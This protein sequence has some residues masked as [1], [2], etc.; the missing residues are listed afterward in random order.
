MVDIKC[1]ELGKMAKCCSGQFDS[2]LQM[3]VSGQKKRSPLVFFE[4]WLEGNDALCGCK[5]GGRKTVRRA[6]WF[7]ERLAL[8]LGGALM[9]TEHRADVRNLGEETDGAG[10]FL[11][12]S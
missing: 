2:H 8:G 1:N 4:Q 7:D 12:G 6:Q 9:N 5:S 3:E 10:P 11:S